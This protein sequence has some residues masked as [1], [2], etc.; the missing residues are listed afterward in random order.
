MGKYYV[1]KSLKPFCPKCGGTEGYLGTSNAYFVCGNK[2]CIN[3][4]GFHEHYYTPE[5]YPGS[6]T[7]STRIKISPWGRTYY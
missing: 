3:T 2:S 5:M 4:Y 7:W 6:I 1:D